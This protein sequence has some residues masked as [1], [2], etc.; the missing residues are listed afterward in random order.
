MVAIKQAIEPE[1]KAEAEQRN[2]EY[3]KLYGRGRPKIGGEESSQSN[4]PTTENN[5]LY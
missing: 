3:G 1:I 5:L 4:P 2:G